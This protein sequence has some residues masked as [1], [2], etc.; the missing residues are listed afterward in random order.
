[1]AMVTKSPPYMLAW[2][3]KS[4]ISPPAKSLIFLAALSPAIR[5][6]WYGFDDGLGANPIEFI[7]HFTG[8]WGIVF[9]CLT[10]AITPFRVSTG[11][12]WLISYRRMLGLFCFFYALLHFLTWSVLD[13]NLDLDEIYADFFKRTFITFGLLAFLCLIPLAMTSTKKMQKKLGRN[14]SVLHRL[15]YAIGVF[16]VLHYFIHKA[17][18]N[19]FGTVT[20]YIII[21]GSLLLWRL[22]RW[23]IKRSNNIST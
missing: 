19:N 9:L 8:T 13:K 17:A 15:I 21:I 3:S 5:L 22:R 1:M 20:I 2:T 14:W 10:L 23:Y 11:W 6:V 7:T 4:F 12:N 18:K 16:V